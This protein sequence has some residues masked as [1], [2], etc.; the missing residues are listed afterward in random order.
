MANTKR[1][2]NEDTNFAYGTYFNQKG[3]QVK[4]LDDFD[5]KALLSK[6]ETYGFKPQVFEGLEQE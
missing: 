1:E 2:R 6:L 5:E 4:N 3:Y